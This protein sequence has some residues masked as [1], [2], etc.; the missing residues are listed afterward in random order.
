MSER[1]RSLQE[2]IQ[3]LPLDDV[4]ESDRSKLGGWTRSVRDQLTQYGFGSFHVDQILISPDTY[5]PEHQGFDVETSFSLQTSMSAS[6]LIRTIWSYLNGLLE[7]SRTEDTNHPGCI[8]FDEPKQQ[9][10]RD[11]S[12]R[13]LLRRASGAG[14][15]GQQVIFFTSESRERLEGHL[16]GLPHKFEM[17]DGRVL[18]K[19]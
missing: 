8:I 9:S 14:Q 10:T 16:S 7:L 18:K 3:S 1:W 4:T 15:F 13:E 11:L 2:Q 5:R 12:F 6:D 17:F 19:L